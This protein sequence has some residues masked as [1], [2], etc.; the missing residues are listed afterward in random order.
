MQASSDDVC[1][2]CGKYITDEEGNPYVSYDVAR[3]C[4]D[5]WREVY[6][7]YWHLNCGSKK[8]EGVEHPV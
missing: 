1:I 2:E 5:E 8:L 6:H 7:E 4:D 3:R